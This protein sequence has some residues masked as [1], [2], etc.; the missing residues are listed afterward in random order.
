[1][2]KIVLG[3]VVRKSIPRD[4]RRAIQESFRGAWKRAWWLADRDR[5]TEKLA[6]L[7]RIWGEGVPS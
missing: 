3:G 1:M 6:V 7:A 5:D 2:R 4:V